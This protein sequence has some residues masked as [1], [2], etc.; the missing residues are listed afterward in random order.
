MTHLLVVDDDEFLLKAT[1]R[2]LKI[3]GYTVE[4][5]STPADALRLFK[6]N[7]AK[8]AAIVSDME[9]PGFHGD[10]LCLFCR[11]VDPTVPFILCSGKV[12]VFAR[13]G[14]CGASHAFLKP[15]SAGEMK[16]VLVKLISNRTPA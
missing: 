16:E 6:A 5:C 13:A 14:T 1:A 3:A 8:Y 4:P 11:E 15:Y 9:M 2:G 10:A 7:P 12:E